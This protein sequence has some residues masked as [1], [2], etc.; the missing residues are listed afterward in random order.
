MSEIPFVNLLGDEIERAAERAQRQPARARRRRRL[1]LFA[2]AGALLVSGSALAAG[3]LGG[4]PD[5]QAAAAIACYDG[6]DGGFSGSVA[7][8]NPEAGS[9][10]VS[11]VELCRRAMAPFER[12]LVACGTSGG[13]AVI[14]GRDPTDCAAAGFARL[15]PAYTSA[16][17][18]LARLERDILALE[19]SADCIPPGELV[20]QVQ[21]LLDRSGRSGWTAKLRPVGRPGRPQGHGPCGSVSSIGGD[22]R[23][24]IV[25]DASKRRVSI[26]RVAPRR[27]TDLLY[28]ANRSLLVPLFAE[29]GARCFTLDSLR[30][31][32]QQLFGAEGV[33]VAV[34]SST[35]PRTGALD[36]EDGRWTRYQQGCAVLAGGEPRDA[37]SAILDVFLKPR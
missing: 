24:Y 7:V 34:R 2:L 16:R 8:E 5:D 26:S 17:V 18:K 3:L 31:R 28:S 9:A 25:W 15:D 37:D 29:S 35:F 27:I 14:P 21:R 13:V 4:N 33:T 12:P 19:T 30:E 22:G 23:R 11:P 6:Y 32:A 36:D 10:A 1:G 20:R